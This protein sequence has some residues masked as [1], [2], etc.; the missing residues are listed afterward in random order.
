MFGYICK[1][2]LHLTVKKQL[3]LHLTPHKTAQTYIQKCI[4]SCDTPKAYVESYLRALGLLIS[5][6]TFLCN[7]YVL[8]YIP[9]VFCRT[10]LLAFSVPGDPVV[11]AL[12]CLIGACPG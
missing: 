4:T 5:L 8:Y 2:N 11:V 6:L 3:L 1:N 9:T 10:I 12:R 7:I